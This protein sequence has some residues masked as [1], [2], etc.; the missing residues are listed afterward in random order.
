[1]SVSTL[2]ADLE[3]NVSALEF[4]KIFSTT[5]SEL[6][7]ISPDIIQSIEL[8]GGAW[9]VPGFEILVNYTLGNST[10]VQ[11]HYTSLLFKL[12]LHFMLSLSENICVSIYLYLYM[13][14]PRCA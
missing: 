7:T 13:I 6:A 3:L 1:M 14:V 8:A 5:T 10:Q 12:L 2:E 11:L 4:L 9:G